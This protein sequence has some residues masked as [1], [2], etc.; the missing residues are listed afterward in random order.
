MALSELERG[1]LLDAGRQRG[2]RGIPQNGRL[3]HEGYNEATDHET[4]SA[5]L[6]SKSP[7][8]PLDRV[9]H[10]RNE[11]EAISYMSG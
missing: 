8:K 11:I 1:G 2:R 4:L 10:P 3:K 5:L 7:T 9:K 6:C